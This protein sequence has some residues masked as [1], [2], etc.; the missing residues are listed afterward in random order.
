MSAHEKRMINE[1][2]AE[3]ARSFGLRVQL[4]VNNA[5]QFIEENYGKIR[6]IDN[7]IQNRVSSLKL[8]A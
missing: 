6:E 2:L 1:K 5:Q 3:V 7:R 4:T 8:A